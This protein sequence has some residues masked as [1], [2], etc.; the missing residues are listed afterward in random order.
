M[1]LALS[2]QG[3]LAVTTIACLAA[4]S[5]TDDPHH[6]TAVFFA[7]VGSLSKKQATAQTR[8]GGSRK[9]TLLTRG[10]LRATLSHDK[11]DSAQRPKAACYTE[12][13]ERAW[14]RT[15]TT[16]YV[17]DRPLGHCNSPP[18]LGPPWPPFA[19]LAGR[20]EGLLV[21]SDN[22]QSSPHLPDGRRRRIRR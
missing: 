21:G 7:L 3:L 4:R 14:C 17:C 16:D 15:V 11:N 6:C 19:L 2:L 8:R 13:Q 5:Q 18:R 22:G 1:T 9:R 12:R 10:A 20:F